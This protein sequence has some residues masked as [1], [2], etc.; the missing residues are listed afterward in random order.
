[1]ETVTFWNIL[2]FYFYILIN[3]TVAS[4]GLDL[5]KCHPVEV[6]KHI[7]WNGL[8][9]EY[10]MVIA[11]APGKNTQWDAGRWKNLLKVMQ[12]CW[13]VNPGFKT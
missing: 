5:E 9:L 7:M 12:E 10:I 2:S 8:C 6:P 1:M 4:K 11:K 3:A 13:E